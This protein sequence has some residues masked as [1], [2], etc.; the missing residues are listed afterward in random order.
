[1]WL[2][3]RHWHNKTRI[4]KLLKGASRIVARELGLSIEAFWCQY[5]MLICHVLLDHGP[6]IVLGI[7]GRNMNSWD[8]TTLTPDTLSL[9]LAALLG[10]KL[11]ESLQEKFLKKFSQTRLDDDI[12]TL[13]TPLGVYLACAARGGSIG[14]FKE[15]LRHADADTNIFVSWL[16]TH[17]VV[18][19]AIIN[20]R[21]DIMDEIQ[22]RHTI[23]E[24]II[25]IG[26]RTI[27]RM[28]IRAS[29]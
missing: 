4:V 10:E 11:P 28:S 6:T 13:P 27:S 23:G 17:K 12:Q 2:I 14:M 19:A 26:L 15:A 29:F 25:G 8:K 1:M 20:G 7:F 22:Q 3:Q 18:N 24:P 9:H 16:L 21:Q 5:G